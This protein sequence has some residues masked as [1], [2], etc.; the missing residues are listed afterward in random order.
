[1]K[2]KLHKNTVRNVQRAEPIFIHSLWR[3]GSTFLFSVFRRSPNGYWCYQEPIHEFA[4]YSKDAPDLLMSNHL[5]SPDVLRHPHL[6]K[7]YFY[8]LFKT[9]PQ[10][11]NDINKNIIYDAYFAEADND[12]T[13][14]YLDKLIKNS[15]GRPVIQECRTSSRISVLKKSLGGQHIYL[16]RNPWDQW[17]SYKATHY[18]DITNQ[19]ILNTT[20]HLS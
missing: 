16:W 3:T 4:L 18:F 13:T 1:M 6:D 12:S 10:W 8:E 5:A 17:W 7:P 2:T 11:R 14:I 15:K 20:V 9:W 19:L